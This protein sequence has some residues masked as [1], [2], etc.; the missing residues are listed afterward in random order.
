MGRFEEFHSDD[1]AIG[2]LKRAPPDFFNNI[3]QQQTRLPSLAELSWSFLWC[4]AL[5]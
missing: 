2:L 1:F 5:W 4:S 3:G